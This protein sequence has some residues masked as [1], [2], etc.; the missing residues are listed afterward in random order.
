MVLANNDGVFAEL[1]NYSIGGL[2]Q[3]EVKGGQ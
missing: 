3:F 2:V 1:E